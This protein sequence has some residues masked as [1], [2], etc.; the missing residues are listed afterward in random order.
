[1][2]VE[3][4]KPAYDFLGYKIIKVELNRFNDGLIEKFK[5][6]ISNNN[7]DE[8][9]QV[10]SFLINVKLYFKDNDESIFKFFT[11][12]KINDSNWFEMLEEDVKNT[13][14]FSIVFPFVRQ[15]VNELCD[16]SRELIRLPIVNLKNA[17]LTKEVVF[18]LN[19]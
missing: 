18:T 1:M 12:F 3:Y 19:K 17:N 15:K 10:Y 6:S 9:K 11:A 4:M 8:E 14:F 5:L 13:M 16:D 2:S 7:Y